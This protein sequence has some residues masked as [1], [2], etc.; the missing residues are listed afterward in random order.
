MDSILT[1]S[2]PLEQKLIALDNL[3]QLIETI[4]NANNLQSLGL[5]TP[6]VSLLGDGEGEVRRLAAWCVGTAVQNNGGAQERLLVL[7]AIP[8]LVKLAVEDRDEGV[9]RKAIYALS[10]EVRNYQ[11]GVDAAVKAL[12]ERMRWE[13]GVD[14]SDMSAVDSFMDK[15]RQSQKSGES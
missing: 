2:T 14:A 3:E 15:L 12:P 5:W 1:P 10:S 9:R 13:G 6:L 8:T 7:G 4:D 11:P